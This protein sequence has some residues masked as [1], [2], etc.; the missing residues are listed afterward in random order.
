MIHYTL[1]P[2]K[3]ALGLKREYRIRVFIVLAFFASCAIVAGIIFLFPAYILSS[4]QE[5]ELI[6]KLVSVQKSKEER[7][8]DITIKD[9]ERSSAMLKAAKD[10]GL[11]LFPSTVIRQVLSLRPL[12][13]SF[14]S[15]SVRDISEK[16]FE[17]EIIV[18]GKSSTRESLL[19][20][21]KTFENDTTYSKVEFPIPDL[22]KNK[23]V[24]FMVKLSLKK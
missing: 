4:I 7:G 15:I 19:E 16:E 8:V 23:D 22:T 20:L 5:K 2:E 1:L 21:K 11:K 17:Y 14:T 9:L 6:D 10:D 12:S 13:A 3:D 24:S 18:Q